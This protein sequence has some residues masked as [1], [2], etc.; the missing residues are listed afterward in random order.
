M[1]TDCDILVIGGGPGGTPAAMALAQARKQVLLVESGAGLG[2][3]CLFEGCIPSKIFRESAHRLRE[4]REAAD[5]GLCLPTLDTRINWS[6][7]QERKRKIL[8]RRSQAAMAQAKNLPSLSFA[9]G[10]A[11]FINS[12]EVEINL[13]EGG[14]Q[15]VYFKQAIIATGSIP[16][17]PP[18][19]GIDHP[20]VL[21]SE[22]ILN[23][24]HIPD[25]L[26]II[27]AGPIGIELGQIFNT[28]GSQ[29]SILD[30]APDILGSIDQELA[31]QLR[32]HM[33]ADGIEIHTGCKINSIIHSGQSVYVEY[34]PP[35]QEKQHIFSDSVLVA[36]G[37]R[38]NIQGLGLEN[39]AIKH[40]THGIEVNETLQTGEAGIYALG[41]VIGQPMF[42]HWAT[43]EGLA[44][45]RHLLGQPVP[46]PDP[47]TNSAVIFSEPELAIAGL[48]E[49]AARKA[50]MEVDI[51]RYDFQRDARS[52][53]AGRDAGMLKIVFEKT[54]HKI[55]GIHALVEGAGDLM[56]EA[57]LLV[58][59]GL[60]L[61]L[62]ATA[63][64]PHPTRTESFAQAARSALATLAM[65]Q[66]KA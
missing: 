43:A 63:I 14:I 10:H 51:A 38:P 3:T 45:A 41:D 35:E 40:N 16:S 44:L 47:A 55:L 56:G 29:V 49:V 36:T 18:I 13:T 17:L 12:Q 27:G 32:Q 37:R 31:T 48:T 60:P 39:T 59:T 58:K 64:H 5:F 50:G 4:L 33:Q 25:R 9:Q 6:A 8:Q 52:Q 15:H 65:A 53:I 34:Q 19:R 1:K 57:A 28:F 20:R 2:G 24:D 30:A 11:T 42:A 21:D 62:V 7:I 26:V 22:A 54:S 23:I 66:A 46:F 61:E